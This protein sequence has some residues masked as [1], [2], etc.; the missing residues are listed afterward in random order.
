MQTGQLICPSF[1]TW[2]GVQK[3]PNP[4]PSGSE[5]RAAGLRGTWESAPSWVRLQEHLWNLKQAH[6]RC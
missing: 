1:H 3:D 4:D 6:I 2:Q 5:A